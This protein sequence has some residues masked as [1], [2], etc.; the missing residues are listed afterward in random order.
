[1]SRIFLSI[2]ECML[3][4]T[5][6]DDGIWHLGFA[7]DTFNTAWS[8]RLATKNDEWETSYFTRV[9]VDPY[10]GRMI[11]FMERHGIATRWIERDADRQPGI[12]LVKTRNGE[13]TFTYW[14]G[15][16]AAR[17]LA[18]D[19]DRLVQACREAGAVYFSGITLAILTPDRRQ[20]LLETLAGV[21][22]AGKVVAFDPN[23]RPVLWENAGAMRD[24]VRDAVGVATIV[25]PSLED[26]QTH[27][28][29][30]DIEA[31][32]QRYIEAGAAEVAIKN[33]GAS[34]LVATENQKHEISGLERVEPLDT[35]G[36]GDAFNGAYLA[37]RLCGHDPQGSV[38]R[39]HELAM[40]T[41]LQRGALQYCQ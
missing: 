13:R 14:R 20:A 4:F 2:G 11:A 5:T 17:R 10:S 22:R 27:Y 8:F 9:G 40:R 25:L 23:L 6:G 36:A 15:L 12:Y 1:M 41:V 33:G 35:T 24:A 19:Q 26:E 38:R 28:G 39:A 34:M 31:C 3:E 37:A 7:G 18:D 16:S 21:K 32:A 29:D 30:V